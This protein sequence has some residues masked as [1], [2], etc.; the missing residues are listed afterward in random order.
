MAS[1]PS[2]GT[3]TNRFNSQAFKTRVRKD[4]GLKKLDIDRVTDWWLVKFWDGAR[5]SG[6]LAFTML[7]KTMQWRK[8]YRWNSLA[9]EDFSEDIKTGKLYYHKTAVDG[10]PVLIW[11]ICRHKADAKMVD[12]TVRFIVWMME[13]GIREG[14]ITSRITLLIDRAGSGH[15]NVEGVHFF[16]SLAHV[17]QTHF[18]EM[19]Q[20]I[21]I[22]PTNWLLWTV[23]K[24]A[25]PFLDHTVVE[26]VSV[27]GPKEFKAELAKVLGD[28]LPE[29]YGGTCYDW[30]DAGSASIPRYSVAEDD[31]GVDRDA[32][33][34]SLK[35]S[36]I[37]VGSD[38]G[39]TRKPV[40]PEKAVSSGSG[41]GWGVG[42]V[43]RLLPG[44]K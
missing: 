9:T 26:K 30:T 22:F 23:W 13:K 27:L 21:M 43:R 1:R 40:V 4:E 8:E 35:D 11:R 38:G 10:T 12:H 2:L 44:Q 15:E 32:D 34:D 37:S 25:K 42:R 29:R 31:D 6:E 24:V 14:T 3:C 7:E 20:R 16:R 41:R 18:P 39:A 17:L 5:G 36:A 33:L 19:L 28:N